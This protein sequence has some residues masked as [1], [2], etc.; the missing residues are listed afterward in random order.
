MGRMLSIFTDTYRT[1]KQIMEVGNPQD[2]HV[3]E[4]AQGWAKR[5]L[6]YSG[7]EVRSVKGTPMLERPVIWVGNHVSYL[8]I[9]L[10]MSEAPAVF[11]AKS[12]L[13]RWP[14]IGTGCRSVG[15]VF[16][17]RGSAKSRART[18]D[19]IGKSLREQRQS[20]AVFPAGTTRLDESREWRRGIFEIA[21]RL[22]VPVQPFRL[23]YTP[24]RR[25]AYIDRDFFPLHLWQLIHSEGVVAE[26]EWGHS[27]EVTDPVSECKRTWEWA[28]DWVQEVETV[29]DAEGPES[30]NDPSPFQREYPPK[31]TPDAHVL[32]P[33]AQARAPQ[34]S[35]QQSS[36]E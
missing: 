14:V 12:E 16:V 30:P 22:G 32:R 11:V 6:K 3:R 15:T 2:E 25:A 24:A 9:P 8:D 27:F 7:V 36:V 28:R 34:S 33:E 10:L 5:M 21:R 26:L 20:I 23:R 29:R 4:W 35:P 13:A 31:P 19:A 18:G 1:A 17:E